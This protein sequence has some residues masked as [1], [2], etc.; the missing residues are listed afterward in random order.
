MKESKQAVSLI[1]EE[2]EFE[3]SLQ[4]AHLEDNIYF[5]SQSMD[6]RHK[7]L[8]NNNGIRVY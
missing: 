2:S 7:F 4:D 5:S 3:Q 6:N 1:M 8:N